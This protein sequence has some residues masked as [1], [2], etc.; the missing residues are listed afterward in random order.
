MSVSVYC[1]RSG[2]QCFGIVAASVPLMLIEN[3][4]SVT[5]CFTSGSGLM[6]VILQVL[7][8]DSIGHICNLLTLLNTYS[9]IRSDDGSLKR[10]RDTRH[11]GGGGGVDISR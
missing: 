1:S 6:T 9:F 2:W 8:L 11:C 3:H 5:E 10:R 4:W 7:R